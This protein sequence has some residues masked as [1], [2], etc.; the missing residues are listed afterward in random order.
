M[1]TGFLLPNFFEL[2]D[3]E[4]LQT[5]PYCGLSKYS[6]MLE[7][8]DAKAQDFDNGAPVRRVIMGCLQNDTHQPLDTSLLPTKVV[9]SYDR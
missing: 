6:L 7:G 2:E 9:T 4:E 1:T 3:R 8:S 5:R